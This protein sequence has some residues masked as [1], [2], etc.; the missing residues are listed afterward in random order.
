[1]AAIRGTTPVPLHRYYKSLCGAGAGPVGLSPCLSLFLSPVPLLPL[2]E[3]CAP[4]GLGK[5]GHPSLPV[6]HLPCPQ[7]SSPQPP[8]PPQHSYSGISKRLV[9]RMRVIHRM[10]YMPQS[11]HHWVHHGLSGNTPHL[12]PGGV[13]AAPRGGRHPVRGRPISSSSTLSFE[14]GRQKVGERLVPRGGLE[15]GSVSF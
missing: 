13:K 4:R 11:A 7:S 10:G 6:P 15:G 12:G 9:V 1:M 3:H 8:H 5:L 2:S 14:E